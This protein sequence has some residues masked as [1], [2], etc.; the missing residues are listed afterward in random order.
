MAQKYSKNG[1]IA[2]YNVLWSQYFIKGE[3]EK[4]EE[5][6]TKYLQGAPRIMFQRV[7]QSARESND[8]TLIEKLI[9]HL[10]TSKVTEGA[11]GNAYSCLLD[12]L[13]NKAEHEAVVSTFE[14]ALKEI[15]IDTINRTAVL[16]VK[17]TY[18]KLGKPFNHRIPSKSKK[19]TSSSSDDQ[20]H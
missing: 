20:K 7:V 2:P 5:I 10:K 13:V 8:R 3:D 4:A 15:P 19:D 11:I 17:E 1:I 16:R 18:E 9:S 14:K 12:V 6:W